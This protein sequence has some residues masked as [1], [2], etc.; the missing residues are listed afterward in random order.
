M[1]FAHMEKGKTMTDREK[2][3]ELLLAGMGF[4]DNKQL[5]IPTSELYHLADYLISNGVVVR[6]KGEW[7]AV[8][9]RAECSQCH[10]E[11]SGGSQP[12]WYKFMSFCPDCGADMRKR[13]DIK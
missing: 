7:I 3:I 8:D 6:D 4:T 2:L 13:E 1:T 11:K 5:L 9:G 10:N 12:E